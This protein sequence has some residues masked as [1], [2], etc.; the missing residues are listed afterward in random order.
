MLKTIY[1]LRH[2]VTKANEAY[3]AKEDYEIINT[4]LSEKGI[5]ESNKLSGHYDMVV[6]SNL[7]RSYE[8]LNHSQI[9]YNNLIM[10]PLCR[11][12]M[13]NDV[14][15]FLKKEIEDNK[16]VETFDE[17]LERCNKF[18]TLIEALQTKYDKILV[19]SHGIFLYHLLHL[20]RENRFGN[21]EMRYCE[22]LEEPIDLVKV[23][24]DTS[25]ETCIRRIGLI[26][27]LR[28]MGLTLRS[29]SQLCKKYIEGELD[30]TVEQVADRMAQVHYLFNYCDM[31]NMLKQYGKEKS[32]DEIEA[33][34]M[35]DKEYPEKWPWTE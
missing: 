24:S 11:E 25:K 9:T 2:A 1:F 22:N 35:K 14:T 32:F 12:Y 30:M 10:T 17:L 21:C 23:W 18:K 6:A 29:D 3:D 27:E 16:P 26:Q 4:P 13:K 28:K 31:R 34:I 15:S 19:I 8:T 20:N 5:L 7:K 33:M